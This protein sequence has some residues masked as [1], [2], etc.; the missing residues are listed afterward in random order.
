MA[1]SPVDAYNRIE[2]KHYAHKGR[3][4]S[5]TPIKVLAWQM[6]AQVRPDT[7]TIAQRK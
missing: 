2:H 3:P 6:Q 7:E 5:T 4:T 1:V